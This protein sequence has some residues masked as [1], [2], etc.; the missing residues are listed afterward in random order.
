MKNIFLLLWTFPGTSA[1]SPSP[2][3]TVVQEEHT[4]KSSAQWTYIDLFAQTFRIYFVGKT[5]NEIWRKV[6]RENVPATDVFVL[7][8]WLEM[9]LS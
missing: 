4:K 3:H 8:N 1:A 5:G 7:A 6:G 2:Q 9:H